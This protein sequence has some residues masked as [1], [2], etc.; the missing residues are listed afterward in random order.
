MQR[1]GF[2]LVVLAV[3]LP[4][5]ASWAQQE[6]N[7]PQCTLA[8]P[9]LSI[10][11]PDIF[12]DQQEQ[13]L[14][15]AEASQLEPD[16]VLLPETESAELTRIGLKLLAQLP[17]TTVQYHFKVY[18]SEEANAFSIAGGDVYVGRKLITDA[19]SEDELAA[20]LAHEIGHIYTRQIAITYTRH[21]KAMLNVT[22]LGGR[23]D[24][25]EKIQLLLNAPWKDSA[26]ESGDDEKKDELIA[27][28]VGLYAM[29]KAGYAP[30][31]FA[32]NLDRISSN[33]GHTG[34]FLT[35]VVAATSL[36]S[37]RVRV[38]RE[39]A[40]SLPADCEGQEPG[41]SAEF[42]AFQEAIRNTTI[43]WLV[44]PTPDLNSFKLEPPVRPALTKVRFS[45]DGN[46]ILAQD[47]T[48]IH[49][50]SRSPL[51]LLF[52]I[53]APG[54]QA[55]HFTPDSAHV[56]F[57]YSTMRVE[58]WGVASGKR[59]SYHELVDYDGCQETSLSPDGKTFLCFSPKDDGQW[60]KLTDVETG[61]QLYSNKGFPGWDPR[62]EIAYSQ[63]GQYLFIAA[64]AKAMAWDLFSH[65]EVSLGNGLSHS[66]Q[67][68]A[69]FIDSD[70]LAFECDADYKADYT[71]NTY[72]WC[73][74]TFPDGFSIN[75][76]K[77]GYQWVRPI[78][79]GNRVVIGPFTDSAAM[80][81]DPSTGNASAGFKLET[82]D[83]YGQ[84]LASENA[85]GGVTVGELGSPH[86]ESV[87]L[88]VS[89]MPGV[90][91]AD[92]SLDGRFLAF[93][94]ET[95]GSIWD[96]Q[97]RKRVALMRPF[98]AVHF[99]DH[100]QMYAQY[101]D[102]HQKPGQ[103]SHIDLTSGQ[104]SEEAKYDVEQVQYGDVLVRSHWNSVRRHYSYN[105]IWISKYSDVPSD[106]DLQVFDRRTGAALWS[107]HF[108]H[109]MPLIRATDSGEL[110]LFEDLQWQT[111][112]DES[113]R[114]GSKLVKA[115]DMRGEW[116]PQGLLAEVIESRTGEVRGAIEAPERGPLT[117]TDR[118]TAWL[119][120]NYLIMHGNDNNS[121][122]YRV[123]D[124]KRLGA[125][126]GD[127][128]TGDGT[129]GLI[130]A[131]NS[132]QEIAIYDATT[133]K[134]LKRVV[135]DHYPLAARFIAAKKTLLVLTASQMVYSI[136][137]P[138]A[139]PDGRVKG[140]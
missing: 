45:T 96:L 117:G 1:F 89:P 35:D 61:K 55:A 29:V 132:R 95:R 103:N 112:V 73:E 81:V 23:D 92:F 128:L 26:A 82:L 101:E 124:G 17:P 16:H 44:Q 130:A 19:R 53:E 115:S 106:T 122:I 69:A 79:K 27:D 57:H 52:S 51:K 75:K 6:K 87:D 43:Q 60:L 71:R 118:R 40:A 116:S 54:A 48:R 13:W 80:L 56:V 125:F 28:R 9:A 135:L 107:K 134:A 113:A 105:N 37:L 84:T 67:G 21:L 4:S 63:N 123:T 114:A 138:E 131:S 127:V 20:V 31:A 111:A 74:T 47:E 100:D 18:E 41:S 99:D 66:V 83:M 65:R 38:A 10:N 129:L 104:V 120:G 76:F 5:R 14:G 94:G 15:E 50:L 86:V 30:R 62:G 11:K 133:G 59:E 109:E 139:G 32:E 108:S 97:T 137:L 33:K 42:K 70:K 77:L 126:Y 93:S 136:E 91:A 2:V 119:F 88:P 3:A 64:G 90:I 22:S 121:V 36:I 110:L 68:P 46:Y 102:S 78:T 8:M 49:V 140:Q 72:T 34:N 25:E 39:I 24:V 7:A 98:R 12:N 85:Q 58:Q